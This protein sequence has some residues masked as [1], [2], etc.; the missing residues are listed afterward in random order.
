MSLLFKYTRAF[1]HL[2]RHKKSQLYGISCIVKANKPFTSSR[3][4]T[5][6]FGTLCRLLLE[7]E[8]GLFV[9]LLTTALRLCLGWVDLLF[10]PLK[11]HINHL[12]N[13]LMLCYCS[14]SEGTD[15]RHSFKPEL[16]SET[17]NLHCYHPKPIDPFPQLLWTPMRR[18]KYHHS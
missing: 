2:T 17:L 13:V 12:W 9:W 4:T 14:V 11:L 15:H 8:K 6:S 10:L 3:D 1:Y 5:P 16:T 18:I 7:T